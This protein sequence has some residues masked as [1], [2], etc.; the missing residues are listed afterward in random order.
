MIDVAVTVPPVRGSVGQ[1]VDLTFRVT[2]LGPSD[3]GGPG[4]LIVAPSGTV[5]LPAQWC[6]TDGTPHQQ[7]PEST[8]VRC[9]FESYFPTMHSGHGRVGQTI[10][11]RIKSTPGRDGSI[12]ASGE[13]A[14]GTEY[15]P[16]NNT[17]RIVGTA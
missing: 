17:A 5:L 12:T 1:T 3:G 2:D 4:V 8:R 10:G 9:N 6:W 11:L 13:I 16:R 7:L 15:L 14:E